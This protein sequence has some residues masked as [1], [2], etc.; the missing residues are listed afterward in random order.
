MAYSR[1]GPTPWVRTSQPSCVS[2]GEPQLP[3]WI[4]S[5]GRSG[6]WTVMASPQ[7]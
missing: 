5:H 1:I 7:R 6:I 3:S 2:I 4:S